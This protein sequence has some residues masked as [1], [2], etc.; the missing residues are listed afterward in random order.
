MLLGAE[1]GL[2]AVAEDLLTCH[3]RRRLQAR[4]SRTVVVAGDQVLGGVASAKGGG[5]VRVDR[6]RS[7]C[8]APWN[9]SSPAGAV[10]PRGRADVNPERR[11]KSLPLSQSGLHV[12]ERHRQRFE[13]V[14]MKHRQACLP[15]DAATRRSP[16]ARS[17]MKCRDGANA[18]STVNR[19]AKPTVN[20]HPITTR[21]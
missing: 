15:S 16:W 5:V 6:T 13:V 14:L 10:A 17:R 1:D 4:R 8:G 18:T 12:V 19:T 9:T 2:S 11:L 20:A 3:L 7:P 21:R